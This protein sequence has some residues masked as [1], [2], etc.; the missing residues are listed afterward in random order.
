MF[1]LAVPTLVSVRNDM[2]WKI[3]VTYN[4]GLWGSPCQYTVIMLGDHICMYS[5]TPKC[6]H[7]WE[8]PD[9][10]GVLFFFFPELSK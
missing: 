3:T 9:C 10:Q 2:E 6:R 5:G 1:T 4:A 7:F 8:C